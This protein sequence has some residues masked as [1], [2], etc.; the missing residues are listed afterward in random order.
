MTATSLPTSRRTRFASAAALLTAVVAGSTLVAPAASA[1]P[2][3]PSLVL[4][5][6]EFPAGSS[7]YMTG[8]P[9]PTRLKV[10]TNPPPVCATAIDRV[11]RA[12]DSAQGTSATARNGY[13]L[14][15][16]SVL[17]PQHAGV[18]RAATKACGGPVAELPVPGDLVRFNPVV[19][20]YRDDKRTYA[21]EGV[22]DVAGRTVDVYVSGLG[23]TP[24]NTARF[25][26]V[27]RAQIKKV[28]AAR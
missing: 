7:D 2:A 13:S 23:E 9:V 8:K 21:V 14:M 18:W 1:A 16:T 11:N 24:A 15:L 20:A 5:K 26:D 4:T 6:A 3:G 19:L 28:E 25:W 10:S 22:A 27:F 17:T 12:T